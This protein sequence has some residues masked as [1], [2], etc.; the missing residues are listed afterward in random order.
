M[1]AFEKVNKET[2]KQKQNNTRQKSSNVSLIKIKLKS[3]F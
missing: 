3:A 2:T 1:G